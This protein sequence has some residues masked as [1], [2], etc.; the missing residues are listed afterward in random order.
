[1]KK[2]LIFDL[3]GTLIQSQSNIDTIIHNFFIKH[4]EALASKADYVFAT[5]KWVPLEN[6]LKIILWDDHIHIK[7]YEDAIYAEINKHVTHKFFT[8]VPELIKKLSKQY[9]LFLTTWNSTKFAESVLKDG[10]IYH[11]FQKVLW[12]DSILKWMPHLNIFSEIS[13]DPDFF[14]H[15]FYIWDWEWDRMFANQASI[16]FIHIWD[17]KIGR[18]EVKNILEIKKFL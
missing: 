4:E 10:K 18:Y 13:W 2:Y 6:Q 16:D 5:T 1:M 7:K 12:S 14:Q 3:D 17:E 11:C 9:Q 15:S 8:G